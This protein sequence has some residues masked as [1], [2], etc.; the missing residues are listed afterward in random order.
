MCDASGCRRGWIAG[1]VRALSHHTTQSRVL[2]PPTRTAYIHTISFALKVIIP[3]TG[4]AKSFTPLFARVS[5]NARATV[6]DAR[7]L[8]PPSARLHLAEE[9]L[10]QHTI[11]FAP[12]DGDTRSGLARRGLAIAVER[13]HSALL[14]DWRHLPGW[15]A[16]ACVQRM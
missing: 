7:M 1:I 6:R 8:P 5:S 16:R 4:L 2:A 13:I 12:D 3:H 14:H 11:V 9:S 15:V 10:L